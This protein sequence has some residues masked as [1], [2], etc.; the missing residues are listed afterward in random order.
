MLQVA[1]EGDLAIV[2]GNS[3]TAGS[4]AVE[5]RSAREVE[6]R[7]VNRGRTN[8]P[9]LDV[10][11]AVVEA[12]HVFNVVLVLVVGKVGSACRF[13]TN[14]DDGTRTVDERQV[15]APV[16]DYPEAVADGIVGDTTHCTIG[17]GERTH[18]SMGCQVDAV[19]S[20]GIGNTIGVSAVGGHATQRAAASDLEAF[21]HVAL[22]VILVEVVSSASVA[23][24]A[25]VEV[26]AVVS[27]TVVSGF[28]SVERHHQIPRITVALGA[29]AQLNVVQA[30]DVLV[31]AVEVTE[32]DVGLASVGAQVNGVVVPSAESGGS[33]VT[34]NSVSDVCIGMVATSLSSQ[35]PLLDAGEVARVGTRRRNEH[36]EV[37]GRIALIASGNPE[38]EL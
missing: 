4:T 12:E 31:V 25:G 38:A 21:K 13:R 30:H 9:V 15:A 20:V 8:H 32:G 10:I 5:A 29:S 17:G 24:V 35:S 33:V 11:G 26:L 3:A 37:V 23:P 2:A 6:H 22:L 18:Q 16:A 27:H 36:A 28:R 7:A 19:H 14:L 1:D 34:A